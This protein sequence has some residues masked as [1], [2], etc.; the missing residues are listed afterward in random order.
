ME[1]EGLHEIIKD[2]QKL[3]SVN[4]SDCMKD[5]SANWRGENADNFIKYGKRL[6]TDMEETLAKL[7]GLQ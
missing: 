6:E 1:K 3:T 7:K 5:I 4:F 2:F